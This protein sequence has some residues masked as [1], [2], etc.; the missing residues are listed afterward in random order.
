MWANR[1]TFILAQFTVHYHLG[2]CSIKILRKKEIANMVLKCMF[3]LPLSP[4]TYCLRKEVWV[5]GDLVHFLSFW[6]EVNQA[7]RWVLEV[8]CHRHSIDTPHPK[9]R[10][11]GNIQPPPTGPHTW[12]KYVASLLHKAGAG[13]RASHWPL[14]E[15]I[16]TATA[17]NSA[18]WQQLA[19]C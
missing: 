9:Y 14:W 16:A 10:G 11:S 17:A 7:D 2:N 6:K 12:S 1:W 18:G 4:L 5:A 13:L 15:G 8:I 3:W 19:C